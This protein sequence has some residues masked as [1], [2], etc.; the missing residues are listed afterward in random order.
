[1][2]TSVE[3]KRTLFRSLHKSGCFI[4]AAPRNVGGLRRIERLG[5]KAIETTAMGF[6]RSWGGTEYQEVGQESLPHLA[7]LCRETDLPV[8]VNLHEATDEDMRHWGERVRA[9]INAG[10]AGLSIV[11]RG[12][13]SRAS[14]D[15]LIERIRLARE[16]ISR[17]EQDIVLQAHC[18]GQMVPTARLDVV[19][20][21]LHACS[22]AGADVLRI[23]GTGAPSLIKAAV[24]ALSPQAVSVVIQDWTVNVKA[25]CALGVRR[26]SMGFTLGADPWSG[27][28]CGYE[29]VLSQ[30]I[31]SSLQVAG[32]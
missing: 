30:A 4:L 20:Q 13:D 5:A 6:T 16:A 10:A 9:T 19:L 31:G 11:D 17:S 15:S 25:I 22:E 26:I 32:R 24:D 23:P 3:E 8:S 21:R 18:E 27:F 14:S 2:P 1:M 12:G 29:A 7:Q 28:E